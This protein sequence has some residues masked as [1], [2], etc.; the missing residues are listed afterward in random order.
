MKKRTS[1]FHSIFIFDLRCLFIFLNY[2][3]NITL[4]SASGV[5]SRKYIL[6]K[7]LKFKGWILFKWLLIHPGSYKSKKNHAKVSQATFM[8]QLWSHKLLLFLCI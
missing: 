5:Q 2:V 4:I 8:D 7:N 6:S 3:L 1:K